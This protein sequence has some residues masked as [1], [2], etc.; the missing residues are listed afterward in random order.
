MNKQLLKWRSLPGTVTVLIAL[1]MILG[2]TS[3]AGLR[4]APP[5]AV[6]TQAVTLQAQ[7]HQEALWQQLSLKA[8]AAP[9]LVVS[10]VKARQV[11]PVEVAAT[12][13]YGVDGTY[14]YK[15]RYPNRRQI[16][17]S[18]VPFTVV[19]QAIPD[20]QDWQLLHIEDTVTGDRTWTWESLGRDRTP[21]NVKRAKR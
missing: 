14:R 7:D 11:Q 3:C 16:E 13:A 1:L 9:S 4:A 10:Q 2:L 8:E 18:Q 5:Q 6:I 15:I 21:T 17:Q 12:L 20:T 19:L